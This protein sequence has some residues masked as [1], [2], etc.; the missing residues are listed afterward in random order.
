MVACSLMGGPSATGPVP[1]SGSPEFRKWQH[2]RMRTQFSLY[3]M[4][5]V[6][7]CRLHNIPECSRPFFHG[8][9]HPGF[10]P[11]AS[12]SASTSVRNGQKLHASTDCPSTARNWGPTLGVI[13]VQDD[14]ITGVGD[15]ATTTTTSN[16]MYNAHD[17]RNNLPRW[18]THM[19]FDVTAWR[20]RGTFLLCLITQTQV[21]SL[22]EAPRSTY[23]RADLHVRDNVVP[24]A[25][26]VG[27]FSKPSGPVP[28]P[29]LSASLSLGETLPRNGRRCLG[30]RL[31]SEPLGSPVQDRTPS[32]WKPR[33]CHEQ[34]ESSGSGL[35]VRIWTADSL[36][37]PGHPASL[38]TD[39]YI[40]PSIYCPV[41]LPTTV[42][43]PGGLHK[44]DSSPPPPNL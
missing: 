38:A 16:C 28:A 9:G 40:S 4:V 23:K 35:D 22:L 33:D 27:A 30:T 34:L 5:A 41:R 31:S 42:K 37:L 20:A 36:S 11:S 12:T 26:L 29:R 3:G 10:L 44:P 39:I 25:T 2:T 18:P 32:T 1:G 19:Q 24:C 21:L 8:S 14:F 13:V 43:A 15:W 6:D 7:S 17:R